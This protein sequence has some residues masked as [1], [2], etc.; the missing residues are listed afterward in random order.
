MVQQV[1]RQLLASRSQD[2]EETKHF[3]WDVK[4]LTRRRFTAEE[5]IRTWK[6]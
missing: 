1:Y 4:R 2:C 5:K 3:I 6:I